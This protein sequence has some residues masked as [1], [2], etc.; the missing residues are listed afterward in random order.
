MSPPL[1]PELSD[2]DTGSVVAVRGEPRLRERLVE[3][4][5]RPGAR[6]RVLARAAFGGPIQVEVLGGTIDRKSVV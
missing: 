5:F 2:Q 6:V 3:L 4:G 1:L